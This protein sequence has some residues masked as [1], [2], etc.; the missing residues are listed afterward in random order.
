MQ[1]C[2]TF[3]KL[4]FI[5]IY[6]YRPICRFFALHFIWQIIGINREE[7]TNTGFFILQITGCLMLRCIMNNIA[8]QFAKYEVKHIVEVHTNISRQTE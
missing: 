2:K 5:T 7:P 3:R 8:L 1:I 6:G 4:Y